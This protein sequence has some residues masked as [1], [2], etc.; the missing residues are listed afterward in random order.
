MKERLSKA[1][2]TA[3]ALVALGG[4]A[5]ACAAE[6]NADAANQQ[7]H[8]APAAPPEIPKV[9]VKYFPNGSRELVFTTLNKHDDNKNALGDDN[10]YF[11]NIFQI[12]DGKDLL[13]Q[14]EGFNFGA[15]TMA[16]SIS[17]SVGYAACTDGHLTPEDFPLTPAESK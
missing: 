17:R 3:T 10:E 11:Q 5:G 12:C 16:V 9:G 8:A 15:G 1:V 2:T 7:N 13:E 6:S 4:L 14:A